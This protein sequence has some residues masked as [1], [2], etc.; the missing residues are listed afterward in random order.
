MQD[1]LMQDRLMH[2]P[3]IQRSAPRQVTDCYKHAG[4]L[5]RGVSR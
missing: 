4:S 3:Q 2:D 1:R 5:E